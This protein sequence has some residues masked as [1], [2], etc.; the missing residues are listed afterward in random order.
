[1]NFLLSSFYCELNVSCSLA[2]KLEPNKR[3]DRQVTAQTTV[4]SV[5]G[6]N[7]DRYLT[8]SIS[9]P[10]SANSTPPAFLEH[11]HISL[12]KPNITILK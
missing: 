6:S 7:P 1:M 4:L 8:T 10:S 5:S 3:N 12:K 9:F 11:L 2:P